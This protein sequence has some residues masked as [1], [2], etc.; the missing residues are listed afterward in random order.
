MAVKRTS[1]QLTIRVSERQGL[2]QPVSLGQLLLEIGLDAACLD[3]DR[4]TR[5]NQVRTDFP[6]STY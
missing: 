1:S 3:Q 6:C 5:D 4:G 2:E